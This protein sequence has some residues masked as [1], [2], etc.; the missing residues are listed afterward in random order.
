MRQEFD[1]FTLFK[2][3]IMYHNRYACNIVEE[4]RNCLKT[5]NFS[6]MGGL[7]EEMQTI[8]NRME[9]SLETQ[10]CY[11]DLAEDCKKLNKKKKELR[12][13]V[14]KL[15]LVLP[16]EEKEE[17]KKGYQTLSEIYADLED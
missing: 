7:I 16:E 2:E 5:L 4:M 8:F 11:L 10:R 15:K 3:I 6:S 12:K 14:K 1:S 17:E 13:E 9:A